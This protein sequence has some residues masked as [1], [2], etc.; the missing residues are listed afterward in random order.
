MTRSWWLFLFLSC[1]FLVY[2]HI[3]HQNNQI[4]IDLQGQIDHLIA[5]KTLAEQQRE[6]LLIQVQSQSDPAWIEMVLKK[7]LGLVPEGQTKIY[8]KKAQE[9]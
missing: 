1:L 6:E 3:R 9:E 4:Q 7:R 8:F 2:S 5:E